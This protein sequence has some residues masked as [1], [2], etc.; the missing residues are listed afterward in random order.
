MNINISLL[1]TR[2]LADRN[3]WIA[4]LL[5]DAGLSDFESAFMTRRPAP[6]E[7]YL[8]DFA[9]EPRD[10]METKRY[11]RQET[12]EERLQMYAGFVYVHTGL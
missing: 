12:E 10:K 5:S 9:L 7:W 11:W 3:V 1:R 6:G 4:S 2:N 8:V